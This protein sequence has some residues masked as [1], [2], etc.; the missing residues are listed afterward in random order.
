MIEFILCVIACLIYFGFTR[1]CKH[2]FRYLLSRKKPTI[3]RQEGCDYNVVSYN[4]VCLKCGEELTIER[5]QM[6][7]NL[8]SNNENN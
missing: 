7:D 4:L 5:A 1:E 8:E 3:R 2:P 6:I